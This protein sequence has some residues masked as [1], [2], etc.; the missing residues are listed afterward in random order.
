VKS[1]MLPRCLAS[2][3]AFALLLP[4]T[5]VRATDYSHRVWRT[6]DGLPHNGV[7]AI[8]Q[9]P[10]GYLWLGTTEG[11]AR[12]DGVRFLIFDRS[13]TP[14]LT[15]NSILSIEVA[16]D[17]SLWVGT[18]GGGLLHYARGAFQSYG[19]Q[20]GLTNGFI[21]ATHLDRAGTLWVGT[22]RGFFFSTNQHS[23]NHGFVRLDGT[24]EVPLASVVS[25]AED[26]AGKLWVASALGLLEVDGGVLKHARCDT[27]SGL[28]GSLVVSLIHE[29]L[30][31]NGC[32]VPKVP[33]PNLPI[34]SMH[35]DASGHLWI[36]TIGQGLLSID[37]N[38]GA[39]RAYLAPSVLPDN[40]V[41][42]LFEDRQHN[43]WAGAQD[44]LVRL[45]QAAVTTV[46]A[47]EGL[48]DD[49][50]ST[51]YED[52]LGKLWLVT[53]SGQIYWLNGTKPE[54]YEL[55]PPFRD[56]RFRN[57]FMDSHDT[58]WF[59][60][61]GTGVVHLANG[62]TAHYT[63]KEGLHSDSIRQIFEDS[64]GAMWFATSS[65]LSRWNDGAITNYY[66][67][68]G[69]SYPSVRCVA[70]APNGDIVAGTDAGLNRIH[71]GRIVDDPVFAGLKQEKIWSVYVDGKNLWLGTRGGGLVLVRDGKTVRFTSHDGLVSNS[72]YQIVDDRAG[73]L[74]LS[75]PVG[76][77]SVRR[78][79]L[80]AFAEGSAPSL[81]TVAYGSSDGMATSQMHGGLQP[82][83]CRRSSGE[84]W[85]PS[86]RGAVKLDPAHIPER[87]SGPVL[88]ES[89]VAADTPLPLSGEVVVPPGRGR[90]QIDFTACD[91]TAPQQVSFRYKLEGFDDS[92]AT[93][94]RS[95]SAYYSNL[96]PGHYKF[97]VVAEDAGAASA[98]S[99]AS[100]FI[101]HRPAFQQT[102]WFYSLL[103]VLL[104]CGLWAGMWVYTR[105]TK[106]RF[107]LLLNERTRLA[108]EMHDTVIQGCVGVSTLLEGVARFQRTNLAEAAHLLAHAR[109][110]VKET[111]EEAR[112]AVWDLRHS[113]DHHPSILDL[114]DLAQKLGHEHGVKVETEIE[115]ERIPLDVSTDRTLLLVGREALRNSVSHG[116]PA[117]ISVRI[118]FD[119]ER[120]SM[121]VRDDGKG[122]DSDAAVRE[123]NRHFGIIGMRERVEQL[124]GSFALVSR[125]GEG[126]V[127]TA[128]FPATGLDADT[129]RSSQNSTIPR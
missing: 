40:T 48:L 77:F 97:R 109:S 81:H 72:I 11:L 23:T 98:S 68:Q 87:L 66:L 121:A 9:T 13:N 70:E 2:W 94:T 59:G 86:A 12:F 111:L 25:I 85:F 99:E 69:L 117:L 6:E 79:E 35:K 114:F 60:S 1:V 91:L 17:G 32:S 54:R 108:R 29:G 129:E 103:T 122:F 37:L 27:A 89:V 42:L 104:M 45:S 127:V 88:I 96:P 106:A 92:W 120:V 3:L 31:P 84:L 8:A 115:G 5:A 49:D 50:V 80:E 75:S 67:E 24:A 30:A 4:V 20:D 46:A 110:Q 22:D 57:V 112:Q 58:L 18:E 126:T 61:S 41:L 62:K 113:G 14:A 34:T 36:G 119:A 19:V 125:P 90:L 51:T 123:P 7:R 116:S 56:L 107:A 26:G 65:G 76:V 102:S 74:W 44:G 39:T 118:A 93:A 95:R 73:R 21:R 28:S 10:D 83:G 128:S 52:R 38:G 53:F 33:L 100:V 64:R 101:Y 105:Q 43:I 82:A 16:P 78:V 47:P 71:D 55:P 15:D 124:G 63:R